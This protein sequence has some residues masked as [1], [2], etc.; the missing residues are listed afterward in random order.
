MT[1]TQEGHGSAAL[2]PAQN[3]THVPPCRP[4]GQCSLHLTARRIMGHWPGVQRDTGVASGFRWCPQGLRWRGD[5]GR[6]GVHKA[7]V[8]SVRGGR[9]GVC[10]LRRGAGH[11][12]APV[13]LRRA[14]ASLCVKL[15]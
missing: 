3:P 10:L 1:A 9:D 12:H 14:G 5:A 13:P 8:G 15:Q 7:G 4:A 11:S 6:A 2:S